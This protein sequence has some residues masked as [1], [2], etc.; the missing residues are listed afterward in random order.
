MMGSGSQK[1]NL[2]DLLAPLATGSSTELS[3]LKK[4]AKILSSSKAGTL[5]APLPTRAQERI[6]R[7]AAYEQTKEEVDKWSATMKRIREVC[8]I[9]F[10][11]LAFVCSYRIAQAD[12][13]SFPL[14]QPKEVQ[15]SNLELN[16]KFRVCHPCTSSV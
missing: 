5:S 11:H 7:E 8:I 1:L 16:A 6:D 4:T 12:H 2:D 15:P 13:L 10:L 9:A 14:Q 3:A